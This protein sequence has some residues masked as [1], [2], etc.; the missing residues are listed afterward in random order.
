MFLECVVT[1]VIFLQ[2]AK[3]GEEL[4]SLPNSSAMAVK[5]RSSGQGGAYVSL[6]GADIGEPGF[7]MPVINEQYI[8]RQYRYVYGTGGYDQGYFKN[9][10][11]CVSSAGSDDA[12]RSFFKIFCSI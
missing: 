11:S 7:D 3:D 2:N 9:S 12:G 1:S 10:V 4:A 8:G 6:T 5:A